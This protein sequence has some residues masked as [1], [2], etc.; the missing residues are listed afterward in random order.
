MNKRNIRGTLPV[1]LGFFSVV[2]CSSAVS[3]NEFPFTDAGAAA[4]G[5][6]VATSG[7][8]SSGDVSAGSGGAAGLVTKGGGGAAGAAG[9]GGRGTAGA[10][11]KTDGRG[12]SA[13]SAGGSRAIALGVLR[14]NYSISDRLRRR[15]AEQLT[16]GASC[17][18]QLEC[19][20]N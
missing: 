2:G 18:L 9:I 7:A 17:D 13:G 6:A 1:L 3:D 20:M 11:T 14:S 5:G 19:A 12:G 10:A 4:N 15:L 16:I 8:G